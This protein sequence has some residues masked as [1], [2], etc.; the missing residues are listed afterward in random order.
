MA[1]WLR[2]LANTVAE[3]TDDDYEDNP[4]ELFDGERDVALLRAAAELVMSAGD[5]CLW[6]QDDDEDFDTSCGQAFCFESFRETQAAVLK[7]KNCCYCG[8][9]LAADRSAL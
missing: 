9:T 2:D 1:N 7:M 4:M 6:V 8:K 3:I 5:V